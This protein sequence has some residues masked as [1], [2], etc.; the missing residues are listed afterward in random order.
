[1]S[2]IKFVDVWNDVETKVVNESGKSCTYRSNVPKT[3]ETFKQNATRKRTYY[4]CIGANRHTFYD[5]LP[6]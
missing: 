4:D 1:M 3:V 5:N 6:V 2:R